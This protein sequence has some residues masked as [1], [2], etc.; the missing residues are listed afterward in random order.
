[1]LHP[2]T[3]PRWLSP[4][5]LV[6]VGFL[7][8]SQCLTAALLGAGGIGGRA[9][10]AGLVATAVASAVLVRISLRQDAS[11][12][13]ADVRA[14]LGAAAV[15]AGL[16]GLVS[17]LSGEGLAAGLALG[18]TIGLLPSVAAGVV[19]ALLGRTIRSV[20]MF[21]AHDAIERVGLVAGGAAGLAG[22]V[23]I[24]FVAPRYAVIPAGSAALG[25]V[26]L[27]GTW[28]RDVKRCAWLRDVYDGKAPGYQI[29]PLDDTHV[30]ETLAPL[31][32]GSAVDAVLLED[33][34]HG[35]GAYRATER[36]RPVALVQRDP[37]PSVWPIRARAQR[38]VLFFAMTTSL[39]CAATF[40]QVQRAG[41]AAPHPASASLPPPIA[42]REARG[43]FELHAKETGPVARALFLTTAQ[44]RTI[45]ADEGWLY[46]ASSEGKLPSPEVVDRVLS[47]LARL[48]CADRPHIRVLAPVPRPFKVEARLTIEKGETPELVAR[49]VR[50]ALA[51]SFQLADTSAHESVQFG[52]HDR[53]VLWR[54][55]S[56]VSSTSGVHTS[57]ILLDGQSQDIVLSPSELPVLA[58]VVL[59]DAATGKPL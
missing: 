52:F 25:L 43:A 34:S 15:G 28:R 38:A 51:E 12:G 45:P 22:A 50:E 39:A 10:L 23:A 53:R 4:E 41:A 55:A 18:A 26:L 24:G 6:V 40:A 56:T 48:P 30:T 47:G 7:A 8:T 21:A 11:S 14:L 33:A 32:P 35:G 17:S 5:L 49:W 37:G 46:L 57:S 16:W 20:R 9:A 58:G 13:T 44:D 19:L 29:V 27:A 2:P 59:V 54:V 3:T 42:C 36:P 31:V 1:M